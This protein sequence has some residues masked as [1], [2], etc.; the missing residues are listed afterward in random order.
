[1][2]FKI[3]FYHF[4]SIFKLL[5]SKCW[6]Q[7]V[8]IFIL[9]VLP[10]IFIEISFISIFSRYPV[11]SSNTSASA[12][13]AWILLFLNYENNNLNISS[14]SYILPPHPFKLKYFPSK[15]ILFYFYVSVIVFLLIAFLND[16]F[17]VALLTFRDFLSFQF[18][19]LFASQ[20]MFNW[21]YLCFKIAC[22][23]FQFVLF[24]RSSECFLTLFSL[25]FK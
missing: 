19:L 5:C 3:N 11:T 15:Q 22:L 7:N 1:M 25:V 20:L 8:A 6:H 10:F 14:L 24:Q 18:L 2:I 4:C 16:W 23:F 13:V 9:N 21:T 17:M 12:S